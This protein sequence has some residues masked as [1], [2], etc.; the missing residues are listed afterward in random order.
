MD[1]KR[2]RHTSEIRLPTFPEK[3]DL[4]PV[5]LLKPDVKVVGG[6]FVQGELN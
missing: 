3:L 2:L 1:F 4:H 6:S 5:W